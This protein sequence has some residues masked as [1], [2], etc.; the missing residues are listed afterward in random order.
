MA[1]SASWA[2]VYGPGG[3][4]L[5]PIPRLSNASTRCVR[6]STGTV[7]HQPVAFMP[8]PM[9]R[10]TGA[11]APVL[12]KY[13]SMSPEGASTVLLEELATDRGVGPDD[14]AREVGLRAG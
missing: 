10:S 6:A 13:S 11:P 2:I 4:P 1:S 3:L 14:L 5:R 8:S 9:T 12:S 7:R